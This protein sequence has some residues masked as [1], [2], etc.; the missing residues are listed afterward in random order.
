M[1]NLQNL[2]TECYSGEVAKSMPP[3]VFKQTFCMACRN[4]QCSNAS[5]NEGK[6]MQRM[7]TQEE[8]LL[9]NPRFASPDDPLFKE[10]QKHDF[11]S[12]V[13]EALAIEISSQKG[14]WSIPTDD[15]VRKLASQ[16]A[17][18]VPQDEK[19]SE[20][21]SQEWVIQ[22]DTPGSRYVVK[23]QAGSWVCTCKGF[24]YQKSCKHIQDV[25]EKLKRAPPQD[26]LPPEGAFRNLK[27]PESSS[28]AQAQNQNLVPR[29]L[30]TRAPSEGIMVGGPNAVPTPP[31]APVDPWAPPKKEI[32][33]PVG[34]KIVM[35]GKNEP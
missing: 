29:A 10:L 7:L 16:V 6:W 24:Q 8:L 12:K 9:R 17:K 35:G 26:A 31:P 22:G 15:E 14:D 28:W 18:F 20:A 11:Q 27:A 32:I 21:P 13:R 34:G 1:A 33:I 30:N 23:E 2:F 19:P 5:V 25:Q 4:L 3:E